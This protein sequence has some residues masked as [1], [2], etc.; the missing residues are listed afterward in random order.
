MSKK[1]QHKY[2]DPPTPTEMV[3]LERKVE[4]IRL[5]ERKKKKLKIAPYVST[6]AT[7]LLNGKS[8]RHIVNIVRLHHKVELG[9]DT[10]LRFAKC[11]NIRA[12]GNMDQ[13]KEH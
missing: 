7:C 10:I 1:M 3:E 2:F 8:S 11:N 13:P 6:V 5:A 12:T 9:K 4:Q